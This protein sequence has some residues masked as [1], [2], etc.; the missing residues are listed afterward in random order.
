MKVSVIIT[1]FGKPTYLEKAIKSVFNQTLDSLEIIVVDDNDSNT[2]ERKLTEELIMRLINLGIKIIYLKHSHNRNGSAA[3]NTGLVM[4]KGKYISFLDSDDEYHIQRLEFCYNKMEECSKEFGAVYTGCEFKKKSKTYHVYTKNK[5]GKHIV[6]TLATTFRLCSGSNIFV[7]KNVINELNGFDEDFWRHQ[8]YEFMVRLFEKY[9]IV[10]IQK[11]LLT[12]NNENLNL[13][14]VNRMIIIKKQYLNKFQ[15]LIK[16]LPLKDQRYI[17]RKQYVSIAE[18]ALKN[19]KFSISNQYYKLA[20][21]NG[22]LTLKEIF[23]KITLKLINI[24]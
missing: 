1:T 4:A 3:R 8:D 9:S 12:K 22:P 13:L 5:S 15:Y 10:A 24:V 18:Q 2:R 16:N 17:L 19:Q 20:N 6:Q 23:R 14:D 7:R 11:V 21:K